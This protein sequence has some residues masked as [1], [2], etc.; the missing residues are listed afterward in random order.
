MRI[1]PSAKHL[2]LIG[3][4][5]L[6]LSGCVAEDNLSDETGQA[7]AL[8][9]ELSGSQ[10]GGKTFVCHIPP[11][12]PGN[13]HTIHVGNAAVD[14]HLAHGDSLGACMGTDT[15]PKVSDCKG[16]GHGGRSIQNVIKREGRSWKAVVCHIPPGNPENAHTIEVGMPAV[17]AHLAHGDSLGAC[18]AIVDD[19]PSAIADCPDTGSDGGTGTD[20][21]GTGSDT[22]TS[23][24]TG[25]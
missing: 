7:Y 10:E 13:A 6:F 18:P 9:S 14:A 4:S 25:T 23:T 3:L 17:R 15:T 2:A 1:P 20:G 21:T 5:G 19:P 8:R 22:G 11:G 12:N 24:G 16:K